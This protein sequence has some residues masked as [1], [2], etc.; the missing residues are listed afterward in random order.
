MIPGNDT[1][2]NLSRKIRS[3]IHINL[4]AVMNTVANPR[5][6]SKLFQGSKNALFCPVMEPSRCNFP[7]KSKLIRMYTDES[8]GFLP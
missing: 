6:R 3:M 2:C 7:A 1:N 4:N 8:T 5:P